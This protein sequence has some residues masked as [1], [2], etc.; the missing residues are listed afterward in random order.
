M[1][2]LTLLLTIAVGVIAIWLVLKLLS[3][4]IKFIWKLLINAIIGAI[5]LLVINYLGAGFGISIAITPL[6]A[7]IT[8]VFG[9]PGVIVLLVLYLVL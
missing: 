4:P 3:A 1:D 2:T 9:V 8:G 7:L 5:V 6:T